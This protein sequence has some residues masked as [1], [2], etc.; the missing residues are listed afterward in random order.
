MHFSPA[1]K[2]K[3]YAVLD[4]TAIHSW[5][6]YHFVS[7]MHEWRFAPLPDFKPAAARPTSGAIGPWPRPGS[8]GI[9]LAPR[10]PDVLLSE[11]AAR[12]VTSCSD[13]ST[14]R[15]ACLGL[16]PPCT[17]KLSYVR[18]TVP[19]GIR[20]AL[21]LCVSRACL[22]LDSRLHRECHRAPR[23]ATHP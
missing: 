3:M 1:L 2:T 20:P 17:Q 18:L 14:A 7:S 19:S 16:T 4:Q 22:T 8:S 10:R 15:G 21:V 11:Q 5:T 6:S 12:G 13:R 23:I 9:G